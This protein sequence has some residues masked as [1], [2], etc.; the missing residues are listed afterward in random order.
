MTF[1]YDQEGNLVKY[2]STAKLEPVQWAFIGSHFP[3]KLG[4]LNQIRGKTGKN[5]RSNRPIVFIFL[6]SIQP[7]KEQTASLKTVRK[8]KRHRPHGRNCLHQ[9]VQVRMHKSRD[10]HEIP[11]YLFIK[12][13]LGG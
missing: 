13:K 9:K 11:R 7:Q 4:E 3:V 12:P 2:E 8:A 10:S 1:E 6:E 5:R